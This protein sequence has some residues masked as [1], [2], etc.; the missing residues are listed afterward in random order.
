MHKCVEEAWKIRHAFCEF[1]QTSIT[2]IFFSSF[3]SEIGINSVVRSLVM[4]LYHQYDVT[5][6]LGYRYGFDG[7]NPSTSESMVLTP[8]FV[9]GNNK[10]K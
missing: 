6:I 3:F 5:N 9:K 10:R 7:L 2:I 8:E 4:T 1:N